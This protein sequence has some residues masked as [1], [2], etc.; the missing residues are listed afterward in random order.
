[1]S[2]APR[3]E[4]SKGNHSGTTASLVRQ[5]IGLAIICACFFAGDFAKRRLGLILPGSVLGLFLLLGL[6]GAK[7]VR[8][9]WVDEASRLLIF[10]L[11]MCFVTLYVVAG[12]EREL[13]REW[14][15]VIA[16]TLTLTVGLLWI[17]AGWLAQRLLKGSAT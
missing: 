2:T 16:G 13:W 12:N 10:I 6:L 14:G 7:I 8:Y 11:P 15:V 17:F 4:V 3:S 1:M 5:V 9:E